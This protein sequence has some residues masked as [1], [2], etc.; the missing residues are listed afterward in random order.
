MRRG[1]NFFER[2]LLCLCVIALVP[3]GLLGLYF[4]RMT[5][6]TLIEAQAQQ[7]RET[8]YAVSLAVDALCAR[9][10]DTLTVLARTPAV[11]D[12]IR[13]DGAQARGVSALLDLALSSAQ[14]EAA[15]YVVSEEAVLLSTDEPPEQIDPAR[16]GEALRRAHAAADPVVL[17]TP[18]RSAHGQRYAV[19]L[20]R[21][22]RYRAEVIGYVACTLT[23]DALTQAYSPYVQKAGAQALLCDAEGAVALDMLDPRREGSVLSDEQTLRM[24]QT[25]GDAR[26]DDAWIGVQPGAHGALRILCATS[27]SSVERA[28]EMFTNITVLAC[29]VTGAG[30]IAVALLFARYLSRPVRRLS[31]AMER[32]AAGAIG[33]HIEERRGDEFGAL[34]HS[35][36]RMSD[37]L[38]DVVDQ[39][40][41]RQD[42]ER[43][44][45]YRALQAQVNPHFLY[46]TLDTIK[47]L[48]KLNRN[49][50]A[51]QVTTQFARLMR[52]STERGEE[53]V[54]LDESLRLIKSYVK[55]QSLRYES[56][57]YE[58]DVDGELMEERLPRLLLQPLVEN[59]IVHGLAGRADGRLILR[60]RAQ[61]ER[62]RIEVEDN[63]AGIEP[64]R[65]QDVLDG[66]RAEDGREHVG[67]ANVQGR[68][69]LHYGEDC[70]LELVNRPEGG[71]CVRLVIPRMRGEEETCTR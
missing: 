41:R 15:L 21:A 63:G 9:Y 52:A 65:M 50:D 2:L 54:T 4:R 47:W 61:G 42:A 48:I 3:T 53:F 56:F 46:N 34:A 70:G 44:A 55:I 66:R 67:V 68:L 32:V 13:G 23:R 20:C 19:T 45:Q 60:A 69:R 27:L 1:L 5:T 30:C 10:S 40:V 7:T 24:L 31:K 43:S 71:L 37:Q 35:F 57:T 51:A 25:P 28:G 64:E 14:E 26:I 62:M 38:Q 8:A 58:E 39:L 36:N 33:T 11:H 29:L 6:R 18:Y 17:V 49:D 22:V 59:A 16:G 12:F